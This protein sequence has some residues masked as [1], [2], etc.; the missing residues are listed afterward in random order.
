METREV[1]MQR[2]L[3]RCG[4]AECPSTASLVAV[5]GLPVARCSRARHATGSRAL[6]GASQAGPSSP[7]CPRRPRV[8]APWSEYTPH[9]PLTLCKWRR[10]AERPHCV[11]SGRWPGPRPGPPTPRSA[12]LPPHLT[13]VSLHGI[14]W[15]LDRR[16]SV[17]VP[18][19]RSSDRGP[20]MTLRV[21]SKWVSP[22]NVT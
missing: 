18:T 17:P 19:Q 22:E 9:S 14:G 13:D 6:Q 15:D 10:G 1:V 20:R 3:R 2:T 7:T 21:G 5:G 11:L 16:E 8:A 4:E 12:A